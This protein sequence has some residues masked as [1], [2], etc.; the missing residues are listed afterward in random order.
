M[1]PWRL[2]HPRSALDEKVPEDG[3]MAARLVLAVAADAEVG[4]MRERGEELEHA[5]VLGA[6]AKRLHPEIKQWTA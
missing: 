2:S 6:L 5:A 4:V 1:M 3:A